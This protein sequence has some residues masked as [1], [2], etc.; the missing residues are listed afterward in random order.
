MGALLLMTAAGCAAPAPLPFAVSTSAAPATR[1]P[2]STRPAGSTGVTPPATAVPV[3]WNPAGVRSVA[4]L[5]PPAAP[6]PAPGNLPQCSGGEFRLL[7]RSA[8]TTSTSG[9]YMTTTFVVQFTGSAAPCSSSGLSGLTMISADG[10][11]VPIDSVPSVP[12]HP[13]LELRAHQLVF[14]SIWWAAKPQRPRPTHL[15]FT[16]G[17]TPAGRPISISVADARIPPHSSTHSPQNAWQSTAYGLLTSAADPATLATLTATV[18]APAAVRV[19]SSL[20]YTVTLTNPTDTTVPLTGC[21]QFGE[22]LSVVPVKIATS[23]GARGPL[24]CA[25]L[26][27]AITANSSVTMQIQLDTAGLIAGH[28]AL[29]WQLLDHGHEA[30]A[31]STPVTVQ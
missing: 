5:V 8:Q 13:L 30:T 18:T 9:G 6:S 7:P 24:N 26:P 2:S 21:P 12:A 15:T 11:I 28:G 4:D 10:T 31:A 19:P 1:T 16:L 23:V 25:H 20:R 29:A 14:G 27:R 22:Q 17:D 3:P